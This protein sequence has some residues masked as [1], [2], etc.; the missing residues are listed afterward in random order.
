LIR[1]APTTSV[2]SP[3][4][5]SFSSLFFLSFILLSLAF[6]CSQPR[7]KHWFEKASM[8]ILRMKDIPK[9]EWTYAVGQH[10]I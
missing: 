2:T 4:L 9:M 5:L 1:F 3:S 7:F 10:S 6:F 8:W